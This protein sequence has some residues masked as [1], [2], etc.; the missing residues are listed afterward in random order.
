MTYTYVSDHAKEVMITLAL[1]LVVSRVS[2]VTYIISLSMICVGIILYISVFKL[3]FAA[4]I[5]SS[6]K[7]ILG[8]FRA[9]L[10]V[11]LEPSQKRFS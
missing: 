11:L 4:S 9:S 3:I 7:E 5:Y 10:V 2:L 6:E 1:S 8:F